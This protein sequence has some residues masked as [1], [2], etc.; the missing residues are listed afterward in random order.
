VVVIGVSYGT[1]ELAIRFARRISDSGA[2]ASVDLVMVDNSDRADSSDF[3]AR[4]QRAHPRTLCLKPPT[5]L[6]Y[7]GGASVGLAAYRERGS[8]PDWI[9]V[10][11]VDVEF[12][13]PLFWGHLAALEG[14]ARVGV[15]APYI[16]ST[17][18]RG[19]TNPL[20]ERRPSRY[21]MRFY[22]L[23]FRNYY[24]LNGYELLGVV[25]N[26]VTYFVRRRLVAAGAGLGRQ[27]RDGSGARGDGEGADQVRTIYAPHGSCIIFSERYFQCGGTLGYPSFLFGEELFVAETARRL[28]LEVVYEPRLKVWH[29]DHSSTGWLRSR[30]VASYL[31]Q[32]ARYIAD[33]FFR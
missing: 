18:L 2:A 15:I 21:R 31:G 30:T 25:K 9:V 26:M 1:D 33:T 16:W 12:R 20:M 8:A 17:F 22:K 24:V 19:S 3:F 28:G 5:N 11:N 10:A 32:S 13:D 7:F 6:G 27:G 4:V 23:V 14:G 29:Q